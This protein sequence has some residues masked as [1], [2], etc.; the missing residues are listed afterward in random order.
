MGDKR[1]PCGRFANDDRSR[2]VEQCDSCQMYYLG[3]NAAIQ[4]AAK[5]CRDKKA[6]AD[7]ETILNMAHNNAVEMCAQALT[8]L[9]ER[10]GE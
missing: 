2:H 6:N 3:Y 9:S 4:A 1:M 8:R 10:R 7:G 5:V